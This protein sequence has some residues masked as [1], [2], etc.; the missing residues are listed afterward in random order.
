MNFENKLETLFAIF[1]S[2]RT[3]SGIQRSVQHCS[4]KKT[5]YSLVNISVFFF[6]SYKSWSLKLS[7]YV[8]NT[9]TDCDSKY[10]IGKRQCRATCVKV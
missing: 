3:L 10:W 1:L 9:V 7:L 5:N 6:W 8:T 2:R 4:L